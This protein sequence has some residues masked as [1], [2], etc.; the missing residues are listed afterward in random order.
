MVELNENRKILYPTEIKNYISLINGVFVDAEKLTNIIRGLRIM[1]EEGNIFDS[2]FEIE[3]RRVEYIIKSERE[4]SG[5]RWGDGGEFE[6]R[7]FLERDGERVLASLRFSAYYSYLD[8]SFDYHSYNYK[9]SYIPSLTVK[10]N[11]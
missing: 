7:T 10:K 5:H 8:D 9:N 11:G 3:F 4:E 6:E 2:G 1:Q